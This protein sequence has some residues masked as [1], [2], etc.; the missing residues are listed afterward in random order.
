VS[1][2]AADRA[3]LL[4]CR[5][6][7]SPLPSITVRVSADEKKWF[8]TLARSRG[9]SESTL[10][11]SALRSIEDSGCLD[12]FATGARTPATDRITIR[13]RP[14]DGQAVA[15]RAAQRGMKPS[16]YLAGLVR[17]HLAANPPLSASELAALKQS[18]AVLAALGTLLA[19]TARNPAL[20]GEQ[21]ADVRQS[22]SRTRA[23]VAALEQRTQEFT[24]TALISWET[25]RV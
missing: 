18:V 6:S 22:L 19:Q 10:A 1:A 24:R 20:G 21:L 8:S 25:Q 9:V 17:A 3:D 7:P 4:S 5:S 13:L 23:A 12:P 11:L 2:F 16:S 14:G 15:R